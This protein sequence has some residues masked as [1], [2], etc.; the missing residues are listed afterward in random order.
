[1]SDITSELERLVQLRDSGALT[2]EEFESQKARVLAPPE[3]VT[4]E[5]A[6]FGVD[7]VAD[8]IARATKPRKMLA[9]KR[10]REQTGIDVHEAKSR[11]DASYLRLGFVDRIRR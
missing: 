11:I 7:P 1:V 3:S 5:P 10:L 9:M 6:P 4:T 2:V 8:E